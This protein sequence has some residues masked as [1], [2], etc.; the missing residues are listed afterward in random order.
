M[1]TLGQEST[2]SEAALARKRRIALRNQQ[3]SLSSLS[4]S[5][6]GKNDEDEIVKSSLK[7]SRSATLEDVVEDKPI[8]VTSS[9]SNC[10]VLGDE[11][12]Q[13]TKKKPHI[14][15][16]KKMSRYDPGV[17]MTKDE[18]KAWRKEARRVRNRES[19]A[20]SRKKN[21][22]SIQV[23][24]TKVSDIKNKYAAALRYILD[25]ENV[26]QRKNQVGT[27]SSSSFPNIG[28]H[29]DLDELRKTIQSCSS[30]NNVSYSRVCSPVLG[31]STNTAQT[32][33]PL[34]SLSRIDPVSIQ[35][36]PQVLL[37][38]P[39]EVIGDEIYRRHPKICLSNYQD[40]NTLNQSLSDHNHHHSL[41]RTSNNS[42][43]QH[44][45]DT[46]IIRPIAC[47]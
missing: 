42:Q 40:K 16:I 12:I 17:S 20:A 1:T 23:L 39:G 6:I 47:V 46:M 8:I 11:D 18:L 14:T 26:M 21:R 22:E 45:I 33:L 36:C 27:S 28:L 35:I 37:K 29:E 25:I 30:K 44:I 38:Q 2:S 7:R 31:E 13:P 9:S 43:Q 5:T 19:A 3:R 41:H 10:E 24:E 34:H 15:G 32:V 4:S